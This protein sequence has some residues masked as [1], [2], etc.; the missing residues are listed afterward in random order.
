[1]CTWL[2]VLWSCYIPYYPETT[3]LIEWQNSLWMC[4]WDSSWDNDAPSFMMCHVPQIDIHYIVLCPQYVN[5]W[6]QG[7]RGAGKSGPNDHQSQW[8]LGI[9][10]PVPSTLSPVALDIRFPERNRKGFPSNFTIKISPLATSNSL[11]PEF[12]RQTMVSPT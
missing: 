9:L 12:S 3:S 4:R 1:M 7:S 8:S 10:F 11:Y 6:I 5:I 2:W